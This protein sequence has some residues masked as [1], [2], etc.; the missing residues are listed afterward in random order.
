MEAESLGAPLKD[1]W[2]PVQCA[3]KIADEPGSCNLCNTSRCALVNWSL[4]C[5]AISTGGVC[6]MVTCCFAEASG[7]QF[8]EDFENAQTG[9]VAAIVW[10]E[11]LVRIVVLKGKCHEQRCD[12]IQR[13]NN[14]TLRRTCVRHL[15]LPVQVCCTCDYNYTQ[16]INKVAK[17]MTDNDACELVQSDCRIVLTTNYCL[18]PCSP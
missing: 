17:I 18:R 7:A 9:E 3:S 4:V 14:A 8:S 1:V 13:L 5:A 16:S 2:R 6:A 15:L 11:V 12:R 10:P